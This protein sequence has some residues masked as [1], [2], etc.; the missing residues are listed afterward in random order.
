M[1]NQITDQY[2]QQQPAG[3]IKQSLQPKSSHKQHSSK[4][5]MQSGQRDSDNF[6]H[7]QRIV[8]SGSFTGEQ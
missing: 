7:V 5:V 6:I 4:N 2:L 1:H 8:P 3:G